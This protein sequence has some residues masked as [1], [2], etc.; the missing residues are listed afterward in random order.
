ML[1]LSP[2]KVVQYHRPVSISFSKRQRN[3]R[4]R[5]FP[6]LPFLCFIRARGTCIHG[7]RFIR[8]YSEGGDARAAESTSWRGLVHIST[9]VPSSTPRFAGRVKYSTAPPALAT[10]A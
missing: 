7:R 10:L 1:L 2:S 8:D 6:P 5:L 9:F 3:L 4:M